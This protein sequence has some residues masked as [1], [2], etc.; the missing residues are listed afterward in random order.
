MEPGRAAPVHFDLVGRNGLRGHALRRSRCVARL[1]PA[2][3]L[4]WEGGFESDRS[5]RHGSLSELRPDRISRS[6]R[7]WQRRA[8]WSSESSL[9]DLYGFTVAPPYQVADVHY[10]LP[11]LFTESAT[12]PGPPSVPKSNSP[13]HGTNRRR[14]ARCFRGCQIHSPSRKDREFHSQRLQP[15]NRSRSLPQPGQMFRQKSLFR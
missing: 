8:A 12:A 13:D 9:L 1:Q 2:A 14:A 10:L 11:M 6:G 15:R 7:V 5:E 3:D 4:R